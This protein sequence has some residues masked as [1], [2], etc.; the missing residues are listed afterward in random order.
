MKPEVENQKLEIEIEIPRTGP[1]WDEWD[2]GD[3]WQKC[4]LQKVSEGC[5]RLRKGIFIL[6]E[7]EAMN[8]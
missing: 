3:K 1:I 5:G 7:P 6:K 2:A 4:G 8:R